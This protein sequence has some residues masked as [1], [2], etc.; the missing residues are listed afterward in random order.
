MDMATLPYAD[1]L[2]NQDPLAVLSETPRR[3]H[4]LRELLGD[5]GLNA[6]WA[7]GKWT[8]AQIFSHLA[9]CEIAFG[10]RY[11]QVLAEDN[12]SVQTFDQDA[13]AK[14]YPLSSDLALQAFSAL[15]GWNLAL[16]RKA[17]EGSF[18]KP[19]S[20]PE[21]GKLTLGNLIQIAAGH[22]LNHLRQIDKLASQRPLA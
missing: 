2:G 7:P 12:H 6:P 14:Q 19:V 4:A 3:L 15:R 5:S 10:F 11:R 20:H 18:S 1:L 17:A 16:L 22:D 8:G 9:D 13:W 21:R